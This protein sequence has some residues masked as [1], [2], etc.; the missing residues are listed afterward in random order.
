M[1]RR[2]ATL[3]AKSRRPWVDTQHGARESA[4][5][6]MVSSRQRGRVRHDCQLVGDARRRITP[7]RWPDGG[8]LKALRFGTLLMVW[9]LSPWQAAAQQMS[10]GELHDRI[11]AVMARR[12]VLPPATDTFVSWEERG[13]VLYHTVTRAGGTV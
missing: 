2:P 13:P 9:T 7:I 11:V 5:R 6:R 8:H 4:V 10:N 1:R 12:V 3:G